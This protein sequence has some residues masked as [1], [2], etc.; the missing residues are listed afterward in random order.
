VTFLFTDIEGS[1]A[2]WE[3]DRPA[4]ATA[5][6][7]HLHLLRGAIEAHGGILFKVVGDAVQAAFATAPAAIAAG[8]DGQRTLLAENWGALGHLHVRMAL[9]VGEATPDARGDYLAT[10]L[11]RLSRLLVSGYGSQILLTQAVQQLARDAL[12]AGAA[13]RDLGEHRLRDLLEPERVFQLL[14]PDLPATFLPLR[15]LGGQPHNLPLQP[16]PFLGRERE[17]GEVVDLLRRPGIRLL[18]LTGP[19]GIGKT[20]LALQAAELMEHFADGAFFVPLA[21][22]ANP[23][24][25]PSA[26]A[27]AL[28]IREE[29]GQP[30]NQRLGDFLADKQLLVVLDNFE[31]LIEAASFVGELLSAAPGLKVLATS[32]LPLHL[33]AEREYPVP[34]L[35][36]PRR[37]PPPPVDQLTQYEA[38]RLFID[39]AQAVQ[40][41][42][43][44]DTA[45]A[46]AIAEISHRLDGLPLAI[47]LA[48]ARVRLLSPQAMLARLE[49]RLPLLTAGARDAPARQRTLRDTIAWSYD[50]LDHDDQILFRRLAVFAGG[51][52][53]Q[54]AEAVATS[55]GALDVFAGL[56]RLVEHNLVRQETGREGEPRFTM[57]ETIREFGLER[58]AESDEEAT[59]RDAHAGVFRFLGENCRRDF[60][61]RRTPWFAQLVAEADNLRAALAWI[62]QR[63]DRETGLALA[64]AL[65]HLAMQQGGLAD[66]QH[67]LSRF[68]AGDTFSSPLCPPAH[69]W[70][71]T[72]ASFLGDAVQALADAT[73][74][75]ELA[76][77]VGSDLDV[78]FAWLVQG[79]ALMELGKEDE[80]AT[81]FRDAVAIGEPLLPSHGAVAALLTADGHSG[82]G[83]LAA[84]HGD[85]DAAAQHYEAALLVAEAGGVERTYPGVLLVNLAAIE[86][87]RGR[88]GRAATL[89]GQALPLLWEVHDLRLVAGGLEEAAWYASLIGQNVQ[90]ARLLGAARA[91]ITRM[92]FAEEPQV[93]AERERLTAAVQ[94]ALGPAAFADAWK[95][96]QTLPVE[97]ALNEVLVLVNGLEAGAKEWT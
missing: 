87:Q 81:H 46:P 50:L 89:L 92:R 55:A 51:A 94:N 48:A 86:R 64:T 75:E 53:L 31:H 77:A 67:W 15:S 47:E 91:L 74:G 3:R 78:G 11:N 43:T 1:T 69:C 35:A 97:T 8:L 33:R 34:P 42:F 44:A 83:V 25:V 90:A 45:N 68:L 56:E 27:G 62:D 71:A 82:L 88:E 80:A 63:D 57:L 12:P 30:I 54:T 66:A 65:A 59:I 16:T 10:P 73:A 72:M 21:L 79:M 5:V 85:R 96:G 26:I 38:V 60:A 76:L 36:L 9:H 37:K 17:V 19:G 18:T 20:R 39:R 84:I 41:D 95:D 7:R 28:G 49:K 32:R 13:L 24:L 61:V 58:L 93:V 14:H 70:A 22:L 2:L 6:E 40:P 52:T 4:M 29:G 23:A